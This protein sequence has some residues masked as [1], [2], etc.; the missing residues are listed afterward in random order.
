MKMA[1]KFDE[2]VNFIFVQLIKQEPADCA[3]RDKI[4]LAGRISH[5][6]EESGM[7]VFVYTT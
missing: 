2:A 5:R 6:M 3:R 7:C 4:D 1:R